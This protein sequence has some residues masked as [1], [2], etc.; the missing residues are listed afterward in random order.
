VTTFQIARG[1]GALDT[2]LLLIPQ[3]LAA[4]ALMPIVGQAA[5]PGLGTTDQ[6]G[7]PAGGL[8]LLAGAA[9]PPTVM[10]AGRCRRGLRHYGA[11]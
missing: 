2:G 8:G 1:E 9:A 6:G 3:G 4:A 10:S 11:C 5:L 7:V